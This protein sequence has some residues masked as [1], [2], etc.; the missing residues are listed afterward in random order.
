[1]TTARLASTDTL[2]RSVAAIQ[3]HAEQLCPGELHISD[4]MSEFSLDEPESSHAGHAVAASHHAESSHAAF[5]AVDWCDGWSATAPG[6]AVLEPLPMTTYGL[7]QSVASTS[8]GAA[9]AEPV[10]AEQEG[11]WDAP[12]PAEREGLWA[13]PALSEEVGL[14]DAQAPAQREGLWDT[15]AP[16]EAEGLWDGP[17]PAEREGLWDASA[18]AELKGLWESPVLPPAAAMGSERLAESPLPG[19]MSELQQAMSASMSSAGTPASSVHSS[20]ES[21]TARHLVVRRRLAQC[22]AV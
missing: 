8:V 21:S 16:A 13:S 14:W 15:P 22:T 12:A 11:L 6:A 17:A 9:Y 4:V 1:M 20:V 5:G 18:P 19:M 2:L 3:R 7:P 10:P